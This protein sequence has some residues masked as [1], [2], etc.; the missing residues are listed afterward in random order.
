M[1]VADMVAIGEETG[2]LAQS[3]KKIADS[4]DKKIDYSIK[5]ITSLLEPVII[6]I[7]GLMVALLHFSMFMQFSNEFYYTISLN[8]S[9]LIG[10]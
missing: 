2:K 1:I 6:L 8:S 5:T 10:I 3:L 4:F 7:V 9:P